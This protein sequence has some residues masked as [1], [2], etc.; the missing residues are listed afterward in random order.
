MAS[1]TIRVDEEVYA[2]ILAAKRRL[3]VATGQIVTVGKTVAFLVAL[4]G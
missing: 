4:A 1:R 2:A 3:E